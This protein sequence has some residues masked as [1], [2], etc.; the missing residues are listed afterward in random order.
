V[1][2]LCRRLRRC[3]QLTDVEALGVGLVNLEALTA[4]SVNFEW[5]RRVGRWYPGGGAGF[6]RGRWSGALRI[7]KRN[8]N[9]G[10]R[11]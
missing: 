4:L 6:G 10:V 7:H 8:S 2:V 5:C 1:A 9:S 3:S 11:I